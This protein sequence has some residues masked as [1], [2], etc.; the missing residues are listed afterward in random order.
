VNHPSISKPTAPARL[1][2]VP[3]IDLG[4]QY[5]QIRDQVLAAIE[6]V[7]SSQHF[8]L[9][10]EVNALESEVA[11]FCGTTDA[12]GCA[13]GTDALWLA[14]LAVGVQPGDA[15]ITTALSFFASASAIARA[16]ARPVFLDVDPHTLNL[17]PARVDAYLRGGKSTCL[18]ALLPVHLYGQCCDMDLLQRLAD[19]FQLAIIEDAAQAIGAAWR[20]RRAGSLGTVAAFSF[21]PTK[22]LSAYGDA[23]LVT[24]HDPQFAEHMRRLRNHGSSGR[25]LHE[26]LGWNCRMDAIQAAV[27]RVKLAHI[28]KWNQQRRERAATYDRLLTQS[29][30]M[31]PT[32]DSPLRVLST[33]PH[34]YHVFHQYVI[35]AQRRDN[36]R[37]FLAGRNIGTEIYYPIPL[38]LQP[39]FSYLGYREGD[40][41]ESERAAREV[42]ALPM[43]PELTDDEQQWVV[44]NIAKFYS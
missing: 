31:S 17:D 37:K 26:E 41:P 3:I 23:G 13:S 22:N 25:Y 27:L 6:R 24:T 36:L 8:I 16:R 15:V 21:Y 35:R 34:A 5:A 19:E 30:L 1:A 29:G 42:L 4:R 10:P 44:E 32:G 28:E 18:R 9:G 7:C 39:V 20:E 14:L 11:A 12:V 40:L 33:T 43:F 38:H 2:S